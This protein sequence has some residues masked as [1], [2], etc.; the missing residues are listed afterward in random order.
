MGTPLAINISTAV[1]F[2]NKVAGHDGV[3]QDPSG[4]VVIKPAAE[5]EIDFY[6]SLILHPSFA[7]VAPKFYGVL[8]L[9]AQSAI[10]EASG[11]V[12]RMTGA[13][14][15]IVLE[16]VAAGFAK[17]SVID[18][19]LGRQL[20]DEQA[21]IEKRKRLDDVAAKTTSGSLC[22]RIAGMKTWDQDKGDYVVYDRYYGRSFDV[23]TVKEG[24]D[25]FIVKS[26][27][28]DRRK[29]VIKRIIT[30]IS[31]I[32]EA[33]EKEESRMYSASIL[34][35]YESDPT[36]FDEALKEERERPE[37]IYDGYDESEEEFEESVSETVEINGQIVEQVSMFS[38][39][40]IVVGEDEGDEEVKSVCRVKLIDFAHATWTPGE[41]MDMNALE[42]V[43]NLR[44]LFDELLSTL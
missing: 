24:M 32:A 42:G 6:E 40:D 1:S 17:A 14:R 29:E 22:M 9:N 15:A 28:T 44:R 10:T 4:V 21:S 26:L 11:E 37:K 5:I 20:W 35:V 39:G 30:G 16:N 8:E 19:K 27:G 33:L 23:K 18:V 12:H 31:L 2:D 34:A 25:T 3:L 41:G 38:T 43:Y 13:E 36:A 7:S